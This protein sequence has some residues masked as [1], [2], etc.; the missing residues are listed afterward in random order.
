[1]SNP[2]TAQE[3]LKE[4]A[5]ERHMNYAGSYIY[6]AIEEIDKAAMVNRKALECLKTLKN[7]AP[8][9]AEMAIENLIRIVESE[10]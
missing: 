4:L 3:L 2:S 8:Y 1:M 5:E 10:K 9:E 7:Y 6:K